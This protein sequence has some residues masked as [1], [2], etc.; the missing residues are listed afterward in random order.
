MNA[1]ILHLLQKKKSLYANSSSEMYRLNMEAFSDPEG[2]LAEMKLFAASL[3]KQCLYDGALKIPN[4]L[5]IL[6]G[7]S[8]FQKLINTNDLMHYQELCRIQKDL[9]DLTEFEKFKIQ[10]FES[11]VQNL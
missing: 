6:Q 1:L 9:I 3:E 5:I 11:F 4:E 7:D 2:I 10:C 8:I